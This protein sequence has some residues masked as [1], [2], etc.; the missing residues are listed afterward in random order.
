MGTSK[1]NPG[2]K[3]P[4]WP[5]AKGAAT[6]LARGTDGATP[7]KVVRRTARALGDAGGGGWSSGS[8]TTA[9]RLAAFLGGSVAG[10]VAEAARG[11]EIDALEGKPAAEVVMV[12]LNW[13]AADAVSLDDQSARRAAEA[14]L[15]DLIR[16]DV[17]LEQPLD[18]GHGAALFRSFLVQYLVRSIITPLERRLT[19][20]AS[21]RQARSHEQGIANVVEE[22]V[23]IEVSPEQLVEIDW[24]GP[25]GATLFEKIRNDTLHILAGD[26]S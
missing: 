8:T 7:E 11:L 24:L 26:A 19:E 21:A 9:Q 15:S 2:P 13:V 16:E 25:E 23:W 22:L 14:V 12:I 10:G 17:D 18:S 6:R 3:G 1:D 5:S 4:G 20:N